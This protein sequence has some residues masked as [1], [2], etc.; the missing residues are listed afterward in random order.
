MTIIVDFGGIFREMIHENIIVNIGDRYCNVIANAK[1][2]SFNV[3]K[4]RI[5][6]AVPV[7]PRIIR[8]FLLEPISDIL[9]AFRKNMQI[10]VTNKD[11]KNTII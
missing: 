2:I 4:Y 5:N 6:A 1:D 9:F 11:L 7:R 8:D 3:R 10:I